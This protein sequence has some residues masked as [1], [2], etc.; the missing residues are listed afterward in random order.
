[1]TNASALLIVAAGIAALIFLVLKI[2]LPAFVTLMLVCLCLGLALGEEPLSVVTSIRDGMAGTLGFVAVVIGLGAMFGA[3][4]ESAGGIQSI[5]TTLLRKFGEKRAPWAVGT[6]GFIVGVPLFFDVGF[7]ILAP[8]LLSLTKRS[9]RSILYFG[10]PL[11]AALAATHGFVPPHPGPV[12]V[13]ELLN[14]DLGIVTFY[15]LICAVP[16][17]IL[18]GPLFAI[19]RYRHRPAEAAHIAGSGPELIE[20]DLHAAPVAAV[21][22]GT[23]VAGASANSTANKV[24]GDAGSTAPAVAPLAT[25]HFGSAVFALLMPIGLIFL[26][27]AAEQW[28]PQGF[29]RTALIFLGHPFVALTIAC[30]YVWIFFGVLKKTP[31]E[32]LIDVMNRALEPAGAMALVT[33]A[34]GSLKEVL[35]D[36]GAG[37]RI[38]ESVALAGF[39]PLVFGFLLAA[40]VR[41]AQGSA[42]VAMI[43]AGGLVAPLVTAAGYNGTL[44]SLTVVAIGSGAI[45]ASHVNDS[46]FW[47]VNRYL[48]LSEAETLKSWTVISTIVGVTGFVATL[49][50]SRVL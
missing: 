43:T 31:R 15:G 14:A 35:V 32:T 25:V 9:G 4:L 48:G 39:T 38:A 18:G 28:L 49:I 47:L 26:A 21:G 33:G 37:A 50:L 13:T 17:M 6:A 36:T 44:S 19:W 16:A 42:T 2:R 27:T 10:G 8:V 3:L 40:L 1:M 22:G 23:V 11:L 45:V 41:V 5:A 46:G 24:T 20:P 7:I 12:A 34:G 29:L 30:L